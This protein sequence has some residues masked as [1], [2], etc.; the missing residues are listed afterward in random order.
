MALCEI[1]IPT[2]RRPDLLRRALSSVA[3]QTEQ[4]LRCII[5]D[6]SPDREAEAVV[7]EFPQ[8]DIDYRANP[9]NLGICRNLGQC[10]QTRAFGDAEFAFCLEDDN[11]IDATFVQEN[12]EQLRQSNIKLLIRNTKSRLPNGVIYSEHTH[13]ARGFKEGVHQAPI[14]LLS[15]FY[16]GG[17]PNGSLFWSTQAQSELMI[18]L[19][20]WDPILQEYMRPFTFREP[21]LFVNTPLYIFDAGSDS[22]RKQKTKIRQKIAGYRRALMVARIRRSCALLLKKAGLWQTGI[23]SLNPHVVGRFELGAATACMPLSYQRMWR[24]KLLRRFCYGTLAIVLRRPKLS[25][26][27]ELLLATGTDDTGRKPKEPIFVSG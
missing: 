11:T 3:A 21:W 7:A 16:T 20:L 15:I 24:W 5:F 26:S 6:D 22:F 14:A 1:R 12:V 19:D 4:D 25:P 27:L 9:E 23:E 17:I 13:L 10:Y 8:L 18:G 2:Y